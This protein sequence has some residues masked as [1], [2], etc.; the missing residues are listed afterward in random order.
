[1]DV[2]M[3]SSRAKTRVRMVSAILTSAG[4][5]LDWWSDLV[6]DGD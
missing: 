4:R 6:C 1:M 2:R 5:L 3:R